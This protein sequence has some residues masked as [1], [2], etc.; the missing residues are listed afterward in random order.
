[1]TCQKCLDQRR[2]RELSSVCEKALNELSFGDPPSYKFANSRG[3]NALPLLLETFGGFGPELLELLRQAAEYR[4]NKLTAREYDETTW[5]ARS[6]LS[7]VM[8]R[9]S[10]A[11]H[12]AV[13]REIG[14]ALGISVGTDP[15]AYARKIGWTWGGYGLGRGEV[16][17]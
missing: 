6:W 13:S 7:F 10:I 17:W 15:R 11:L 9:I 16:T 12:L 5:S 2:A 4:N 1:M 14:Q 8:P 3:V